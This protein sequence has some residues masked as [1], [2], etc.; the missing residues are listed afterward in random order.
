MTLK[1]NRVLASCLGPLLALQSFAFDFSISSGYLELPNPDGSFS[2]E[3]PAPGKPVTHAYCILSEASYAAYLGSPGK[4]F[5]D[6]INSRADGGTNGL[7]IVYDNDIYSSIIRGNST[8]LLTEDRMDSLDLD[9]WDYFDYDSPAYFG[10]I[11]IYANA[12]TGLNYYIANVVTATAP[13]E[14]DD[15]DT[16]GG[17][18]VSV[19]DLATSVGAWTPPYYTITFDSAGGSAVASITAAYCSAL[20]AP[21]APT[22]DGYTFAGWTPE[23]P[24]TMPLNG[25][26]LTAQWTPLNPSKHTILEF[27]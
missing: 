1:L 24:A 21:A 26:S 3:Y 27:R 18:V 23:F 4:L 9:F 19:P 20:T 5:T 6:F 8:L 25:A 16:L 12:E 14:E 2:G 22:R 13:S 15:E 11:F 10:G 7:T 17:I